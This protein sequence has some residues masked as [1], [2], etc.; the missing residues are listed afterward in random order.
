M[1][2]ALLE[3]VEIDVAPRPLIHHQNV[4]HHVGGE[5]VKGIVGAVAGDA[6]FLIEG[7][8][9]RLDL[10]GS[11]P[12]AL[13]HAQVGGQLLVEVQD[14]PLALEHGLALFLCAWVA[15]LVGRGTVS[16][17]LIQGVHCQQGVDQLRDIAYL[18]AELHPQ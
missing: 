16:L 5:D 18:T 10:A 4:F 1:D 14:E 2:L 11:L 3:E 9:F 15:I 7:G 12:P 6:E 13:K 17:L 8:A